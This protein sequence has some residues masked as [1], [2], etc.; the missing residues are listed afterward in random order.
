MKKKRK[1]D[2]TPEVMAEIMNRDGSCFFCR[3]GYH[4]EST[5][6]LGYGIADIMHVVPKSDSG[7]GIV[8]NGVLGCRYHHTLM[9]NGIKA[10]IRRCRLCWKI[11]CV[12]YIRDGTGKAS[13]TINTIFRRERD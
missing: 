11:I 9:D 6:D 13:D 4:M 8:Q 3:M 2:F 10:S 7:L 5:T 12:E 1:Y